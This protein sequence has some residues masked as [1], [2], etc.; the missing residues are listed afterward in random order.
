MNL[1][2][3]RDLDAIIAHKAMNLKNVGWY[4]RASIYTMGWIRCDK[5]DHTP[6][7]P[8]WE[9]SLY[10]DASS[11]GSDYPLYFAVPRYT[12]EFKDA[13]ELLKASE[14]NFTY[15]LS[16]HSDGSYKASFVPKGATGNAGSAEAGTESMA[17]C[18]AILDAT[19]GLN[20]LKEEMNE[21]RNSR[22]T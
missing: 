20:K 18:L 19:V 14:T 8:H 9:A 11:P 12:T 16:S 7:D 5:G 15:S 3:G 4:R 6:E 13:T 21:N 1:E 17:I 22:I 2:P 10:Y